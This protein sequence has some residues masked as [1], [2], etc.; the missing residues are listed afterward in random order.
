MRSKLVRLRG[1]GPG[2]TLV[3][4]LVAMAIMSLILTGLAAIFLGSMHAVRAGYR[5]MDAYEN[6]RVAFQVLK[7]DLTAGF[8]SRDHGDVYNFHG[9][10]YG[11]V[12]VGLADQSRT[13][14]ESDDPRIARVSYVVRQIGLPEYDEIQVNRYDPIT[15][16]RTVEIKQV[17]CLLRY[18]EYGQESLDY[19]AFLEEQIRL[20]TGSPE[21]SN[22]V[23]ELERVR[24]E[25]RVL[26][27]GN[28]ENPTAFRPAAAVEQIENAKKRELWLRMLRG[29]LPIRFPDGTSLNVPLLPSFFREDFSL[30]AN[31]LPVDPRPDPRDYIVATN[32]DP[33]TLDPA[34]PT[35]R[36]DNLNDPIVEP[37]SLR[38]CFGITV[39]HYGQF[40]N[41]WGPN[42]FVV[43]TVPQQLMFWRHWNSEDNLWRQWNFVLDPTLDPTLDPPLMIDLATVTFP[44]PLTTPV[45]D[46]RG[47]G[48]PLA[49]RM[50]NAINI[51]MPVIFPATSVTAPDVRRVL[52]ATID[53]PTAYTRPP[54]SRLD[55]G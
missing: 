24:A 48:S 4:L 16:D 35:L 52:D 23:A 55:I 11:M 37:G 32:I 49:A 17:Y 38:A 36:P 34:D 21:G 50:P 19:F 30:D 12:Y 33:I 53:I 45:R 7:H 40:A 27:G 5:S 14:G 20:G 42:T 15:G 18:V 9:E 39:F 10:P 46:L 54:L 47:F 41:N 26:P 1:G 13:Y 29:N 43:D 22:L 44:A 25:Y 51:H 8:T 3:E 2:F 31:G 6:N 28:V